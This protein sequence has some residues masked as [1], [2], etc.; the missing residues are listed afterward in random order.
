MTDS[1]T[2]T[3]TIL[4]FEIFHNFKMYKS[5]IFYTNKI[6]VLRFANTFH[7]AQND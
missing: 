7:L 6:N 1:K 4:E 3:S 2:F 5:D